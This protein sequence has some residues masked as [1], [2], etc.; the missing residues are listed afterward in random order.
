MLGLGTFVCFACFCL[1]SILLN[2]ERDQTL[3]LGGF[4]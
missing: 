3:W 2:P 4:V 1:K